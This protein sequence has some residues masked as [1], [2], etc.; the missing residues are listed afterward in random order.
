MLVLAGDEPGRGVGETEEG[1]HHQPGVQDQGNA[2]AADHPCHGTDIGMAGTV[3]EAVERAEQPAAEQRVEHSGE[4]VFRRV[5]ALEQYR[6]KGWR[7]GQRVEGRDHRRNRDGQGELLVELPGQPGD[8][9][10]RDKHRT[11]HQRSGDDGPGHFTHGALGGFHRGQP[12]ADI[13]LDVLH[14]HNRIVDHD[15]DRQHQS[16]QRQGVE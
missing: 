12:Q 8:K 1:Q 5:V 3:K 15:P 6:G 7:Q 4:A 14:H 11:Q 10:G 2:T 16:E 13:S 9:G